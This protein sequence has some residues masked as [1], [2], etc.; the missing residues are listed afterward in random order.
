MEQP[1]DFEALNANDFDVEKLFKDQGWIKY[2]DMLNGPVYPI[3]VKDFW[4]RCDIIE[5]ADAD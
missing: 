1:V 2:F 4:P 3:L 5:Q